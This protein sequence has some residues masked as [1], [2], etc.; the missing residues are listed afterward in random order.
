MTQRAT[1]LQVWHGDKRVRLNRRSGI[2]RRLYLNQ[3]AT[4]EG[5]SKEEINRI[6][7]R[8]VIT[9]DWPRRDSAMMIMSLMNKWPMTAMTLNGKRF[10]NLAQTVEFYPDMQ[11]HILI[12][13]RDGEKL[14]LEV[15][16]FDFEP[17]LIFGP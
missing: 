11:E 3:H 9:F 5:V 8:I 2:P 10:E 17:E 16:F 15:V 4:I 14:E 1:Q 13:E 7:G 12:F 6:I